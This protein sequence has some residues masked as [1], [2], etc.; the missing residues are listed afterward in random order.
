MVREPLPGSGPHAADTILIRRAL[1]E[2]DSRS[3]LRATDGHDQVFAQVP[4]AALERS[5]T[6]PQALG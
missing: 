3:F 6:D 2:G 4:P 1:P 5:I